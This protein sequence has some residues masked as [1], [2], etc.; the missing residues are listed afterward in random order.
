[1]KAVGAWL[2]CLLLL[3]LALQGLPAEPTQHSMEIRS[4]CPNPPHPSGAAREG[5]LATSWAGA[6]L[7]SIPGWG[8]A[9]YSPDPSPRW[10]RQLLPRVPTQHMGRVTAHQMGGLG[11]RCTWPMRTRAVGTGKEGECVLV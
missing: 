1:M 11:P 5:D 7:L 10:P 4:E 2:L 3:G 8:L 9:S 6:S